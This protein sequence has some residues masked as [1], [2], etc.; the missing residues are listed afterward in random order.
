MVTIK[1]RTPTIFIMAG[2]PWMVLLLIWSEH[3]ICQKGKKKC[4]FYSW[5]R[6]RIPRTI[7]DSCVSW[8]T[9]AVWN[10]TICRAF[11]EEKIILILTI[12]CHSL[13]RFQRCVSLLHHDDNTT[14]GQIYAELN[15]YGSGWRLKWSRSSRAVCQKLQA[16]IQV[17]SRLRGPDAP[18]R[19]QG[20]AARATLSG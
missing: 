11:L 15:I 9:D 8:Q 3:W 5:S 4:F 2:T 6:K 12:Q 19:R 10:S 14:T 13:R 20:K 7:S 16:I 17:C 1:F 18:Y